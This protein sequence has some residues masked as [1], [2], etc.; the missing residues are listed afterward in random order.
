MNP[1]R[2][3]L[4]VGATGNVG[5][6][7]A[8]A[9]AENGWQVWGTSRHANAA[10]GGVAAERRLVLD[11][12]DLVDGGVVLPEALDRLDLLVIC[13]GHAAFGA[14][15][16]IPLREQQRCIETVLLGPI[17]M[18]RLCLPRLRAAPGAAVIL[19]GSVSGIAA[20]PNAAAYSAANGGLTALADAMA[21]EL[22]ADAVRVIELTL[23]ALIDAPIRAH[24]WSADGT[25]ECVAS[26]Y[27]QPA[28]H[29]ASGVLAG[30]Q[31]DA[32]AR[33][34]LSRLAGKPGRLGRAE[35]VDLPRGVRIIRWAHRLIPGILRGHLN[36]FG[37]TLIPA[38][39]QPPGTA[40]AA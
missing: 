37:I 38:A 23:G 33:A 3:C 10:M 25:S 13:S 28:D 20:I 21:A 9:L 12:C 19:T 39:N 15:C 17:A 29:D 4:V 22:A 27:R 31:V 32:A 1:R 8:R 6:A 7:F 24:Y 30:I 35:R 40:E 36:Y 16:D 11:L 14:I 2:T 34:T 18:V 5:S 26:A